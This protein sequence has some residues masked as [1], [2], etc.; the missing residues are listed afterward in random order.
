MAAVNSS[1]MSASQSPFNVG[2]QV[3]VQDFK[4]P[5]GVNLRSEYYATA[6]INIRTLKNILVLPE[7]ALVFKNSK[8]YV[9]M[10]D[11][12]L[13]DKKHKYPYKL[14]EIKLGV[15]DGMKV[16]V[17][18]GVKEGDKVFVLD[19]AAAEKEKIGDI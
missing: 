6:E 10:K 13:K 2:F 8:V 14:Q 4:V 18:S 11:D 1:N 12:S 3:K 15:S 17:L 5:A 16:Q 19:S 9:Y 7:M